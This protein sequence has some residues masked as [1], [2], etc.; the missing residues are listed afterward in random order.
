MRRIIMFMTILSLCLPAY[1]NADSLTL[2]PHEVLDR[3]DII[4]I[5]S[6]SSWRNVDVHLEIKF[7]VDRVVK[8]TLKEKTITIAVDSI[9]P[10]SD[11]PANI[12]EIFPPNKG[13]QLFVPLIRGENSTWHIAADLNTTG[14]VRDN[15]VTEIYNKA[16][17]TINGETWTDRD[18]INS[19]N[20]YIE[21]EYVE[22]K[23]AKTTHSESFWAKIIKFFIELFR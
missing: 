11:R 21:K 15:R 5:G 17:M 3:A 7:T 2:S 9:G 4:V 19:Y 20:D 18:F 13:M 12:E 10:P 8:G 23:P 6:L 14:V 16:A 22:K 1:A